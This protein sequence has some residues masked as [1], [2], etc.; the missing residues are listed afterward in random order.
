MPVHPSAKPQAQ[1]P[2]RVR[3]ITVAAGL[4]TKTSPIV[5]TGPQPH[6][7]APRILTSFRRF[8]PVA[9]VSWS[10]HLPGDHTQHCHRWTSETDSIVEKSFPRGGVEESRPFVR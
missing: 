9:I 10:S 1:R 2:A 4:Q 5:A 8:H 3:Y 6:P 7:T